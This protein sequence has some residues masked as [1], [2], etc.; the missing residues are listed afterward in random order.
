MTAAL[1]HDEMGQ[2]ARPIALS[3]RALKWRLAFKGETADALRLG[4][5][6]RLDA[7]ATLCRDRRR[8]GEPRI[9]AGPN[10]DPSEPS[11]QNVFDTI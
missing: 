5:S 2:S 10:I 8:D 9:D 6:D 11:A 3:P 1:F 4:K 7:Q